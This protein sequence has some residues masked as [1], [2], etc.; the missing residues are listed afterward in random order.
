[1]SYQLCT[2][3]MD[4]KPSTGMHGEAD[5][6]EINCCSPH[7]IIRTR[8]VFMTGEGTSPVLRPS[9]SLTSTVPPTDRQTVHLY[10]RR[11]SIIPGHAANNLIQVLYFSEYRYNNFKNNLLIFASTAAHEFDH[12]AGAELLIWIGIITVIVVNRTC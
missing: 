8:S 11:I 1:M 3:G 10:I 5:Y 6:R 9:S 2:L 4:F 7:S 12:E